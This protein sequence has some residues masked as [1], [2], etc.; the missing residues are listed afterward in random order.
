MNLY[1]DIKITFN[2]PLRNRYYSL[3]VQAITNFNRNY[4]EYTYKQ[5]QFEKIKQMNLRNR[6]ELKP[7]KVNRNSKLG[8]EIE[9]SAQTQ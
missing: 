5:K 4:Y 1:L 9:Q 7:I 3:K 2:M 8:N 6:P